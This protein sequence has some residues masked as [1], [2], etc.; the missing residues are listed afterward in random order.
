MATYDLF[1]ITL[2]YGTIEN[3]T[4]LYRRTSPAHSQMEYF[5]VGFPTTAI[6]KQSLVNT[7]GHKRSPDC[8]GAIPEAK[9][10]QRMLENYFGN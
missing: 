10:Q 2:T 5:R 1:S 7:D 4:V 6:S 3:V 9:Q 8:T